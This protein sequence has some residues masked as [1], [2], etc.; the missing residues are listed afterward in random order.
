MER[1][2][3]IRGSLLAG[4]C[5]DALGYQVEFDSGAEI[6]RRFGE[7]GVR[8]M[9]VRDGFAI[10]SDDTQM[11][12]FTAEGL[13]N[14]LRHG[15][16]ASACVYQSY[17][18][19]LNTQGYAKQHGLYCRKSILLPEQRL[20]VRRAPGNTCLSALLSG[21]MGD[22]EQP[23][24]HSKGC[25]GVM[26]TAPCGMVRA[27]KDV[28]AEDAYALQ[29]AAAAAITHGHLMGYVP[30]AMLADLV[31]G[32]LLED[33]SSL[34]ELVASALNRVCRLFGPEIRAAEGCEADDTP[35]DGAFAQLLGFRSLMN[36]AIALAKTDTPP[37]EAIGRLGEG[38]VGDEALAIAVYCCLRFPDS[39]ED[40]LSAAVTHKGD[41]DSTGAI[42]GNILGAWLG[43]EA[44][45]QRWLDVLEMRE[46]MERM[47]R[48]LDGAAREDAP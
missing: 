39:V 33:G 3:R 37:E 30:A 16:N 2:D 11:T 23:I 20:H 15:R 14:S 45:P 19:W 1:L 18:D 7:A 4:A 36:R 43:A 27:M 13:L 35:G 40:C 9:D 47:A 25:G 44:I 12:L 22:T 10:V 31:H 29:G 26:R 48:L 28:P 32:I 34:E 17:L 42:A 8:E 21:Q 38:W 46:L 5:G 24:N 6:R 41:S